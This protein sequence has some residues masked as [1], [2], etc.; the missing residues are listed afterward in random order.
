MKYQIVFALTAL[1]VFVLPAVNTPLGTVAGIAEA[2]PLA[3]RLESKNKQ[4]QHA[5]AGMHGGDSEA[6]EKCIEMLHKGDHEGAQNC[7]AQLQGGGSDGEQTA[8]P[9]E[10][11]ATQSTQS[12]NVSSPAAVQDAASGTQD[13]LHSAREK[14]AEMLRNGNRSG[15]RECIRKLQK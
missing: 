5:E 9:K 2:G 13:A 12:S 1:S 10:Q 3:K 7:I 4:S 6:R 14:C 8:A 15:A 11:P